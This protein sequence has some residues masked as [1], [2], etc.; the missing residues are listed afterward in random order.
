MR[1]FLA[2]AAA[3]IA[4]LAFTT[5]PAT[6]QTIPAT[7]TF[8]MTTSPGILPTWSRA[9][10]AI[11]GITPGTVVTSSQNTQAPIDL[12]VVNMTGTAWSR[13]NTCTDL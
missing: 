3:G 9:D 6:A 13:A 5:F 8:E 12:S 4:A 10:I 11:I 7:G 1:R 2:A